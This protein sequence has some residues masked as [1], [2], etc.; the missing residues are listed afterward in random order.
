MDEFTKKIDEM[1]SN[2]LS[3]LPYSP[4]NLLV[5]K[6][7]DYDILEHTLYDQLINKKLSKKQ[8]KQMTSVYDQMKKILEE[9]LNNEE[10][11]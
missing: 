6:I 11:I 3:N 7:H 10:E 8:I 1:F 2:I 4:E 5:K 9:I